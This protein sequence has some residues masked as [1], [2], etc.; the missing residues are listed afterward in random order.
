MNDFYAPYVGGVAAWTQSSFTES[1]STYTLAYK[2]TNTGQAGSLSVSLV[3]IASGVCQNVL[4]PL[5]GDGPFTGMATVGGAVADTPSSEL[6][7][8]VAP[9]TTADMVNALWQQAAAKPG[10]AGLP[11]PST[12]PITP[13]DVSTW[14]SD[15][16]SFAP[17]VGDD[18]GVGSGVGSQGNSG[19]SSSVGSL[20]SSGQAS[21]GTGP[22]TSS[23][24]APG[25][26][27]TGVTTMPTGSTG[28]G[29]G[30]GS[31]GASGTSTS[32]DTADLCAE[33]PTASAC[34]TLGTATAGTL[35]SSSVSISLSPWSIGPTN[36]TCPAPVS[37]VVFGQT[38]TIDYTPI[39]TFAADVNPI[40][41]AVCGF[42]AAFIIVMGFKS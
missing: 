28:T 34:A 4:A 19:S 18:L 30:T 22:A 21:D 11:Y 1:N 29:T 23:G 40:V 39:C 41:V 37:F 26:T 25:T 16:S 15:N 8:G 32:S 14:E 36:G 13:S 7:E 5:S 20:P 2:N 3:E 38:L 12:D 24:T 17:D 27:T 33:D 35:P 10:Y 9:Q 6:T 31:T 42:A